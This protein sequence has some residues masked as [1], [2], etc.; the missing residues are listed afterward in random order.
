MANPNPQLPPSNVGKTYKKSDTPNYKAQM[1]ATFYM[2]P[3][4]HTFM[5]VRQ[6]AMRAGYSEQYANNITVQKPKWWV[7][8]TA[9]ADYERAK[10]LTLAQKR[11]KE[12]LE[13][14]PVTKEDK[15][16]QTDVGKFVSE[17]LGKDHYS[18]RSELT[19]AEGRKLFTNETASEQDVELDTLF[20]GVSAPDDTTSTT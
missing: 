20:V 9:S 18:T 19:G 16:L 5:N 14:E 13:E 17:R 12:R 3:T 6:S 11:L 4:S 8:L 7:E 15:K 2:S 10:M 1:F